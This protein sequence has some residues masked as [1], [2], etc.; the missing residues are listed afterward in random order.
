ML[1]AF[2][3]IKILDT[4]NGL[5]YQ[6]LGNIPGFLDMVGCLHQP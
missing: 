1:D 5:G 6:C 3:P 4:R 2:A